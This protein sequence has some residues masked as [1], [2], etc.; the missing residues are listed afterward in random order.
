M[1]DFLAHVGEGLSVNDVEV[2]WRYEGRF[3]A[4]GR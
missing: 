1:I 4:R 3:G 2:L